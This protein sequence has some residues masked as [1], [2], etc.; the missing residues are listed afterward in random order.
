[1]H[2]TA[3]SCGR[4]GTHLGCAGPAGT[5]SCTAARHGRRDVLAYLVETWDLDIEAASRDPGALHEAAYI[6][7][8]TT[9]GFLL[10]EGPRSTA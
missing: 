7:T 3:G 4:L 6:D 5:P 1:M 10:G 9:S 2:P 8:R